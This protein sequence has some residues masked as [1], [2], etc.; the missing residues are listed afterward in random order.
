M[1]VGLCL[2]AILLA[3]AG[4]RA[5]IEYHRGDHEHL[6][7]SAALLTAAGTLVL[8]AGVSMEIS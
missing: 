2:L 6:G 3:I 7:L 1:T 8:A 5:A 4:G